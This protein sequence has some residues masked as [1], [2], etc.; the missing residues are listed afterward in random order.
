VS[1]AASGTGATSN[2]KI[3]LSVATSGANATSGQTTFGAIFS[4]TSTGTT[5]VNIALQLA[6]S[7][8]TTNTDL[9]LAGSGV[10]KSTP[11]T[12]LLGNFVNFNAT[13]TT[14]GAARIDAG[15]WKFRSDILVGWVASSTDPSGT[16]DIILRRSAAA[17]LTQ[18]AADVD[19][20]P[21]AQTRSFQ[22]ALAGG[23]SDVAGADTTYIASRGKG[24][25]AAGKFI[26]QLGSPTT[27]G[28]VVHT[29]FSVLTLATVASGA[30]GLTVT[31]NA[32]GGGVSL[33]ST[34]GA[35][36]LTLTSGASA[37]G[38]T[39]EATGGGTNESLILKPKGAGLTKF[40]ASK[41]GIGEV[42][43]FAGIWLDSTAVGAPIASNYAI[44]GDGTGNP[45]FNG[46]TGFQFR[47]ANSQILLGAASS[48]T[49]GNAINL[50]FGTTTGTQ[51]GTAAAQKIGHWGVTPIVQPA[52]ANQAALTDSTTGTAGFTLSD[53]GAVF[54]QATINNNF[55]SLAR[56]VDNMRTALVNGGFMKGAA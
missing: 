10:I 27:S 49:L 40:S 46:P 15:G 21:V 56:L 37:A 19:T 34:G 36:S 30:V 44:L 4:N 51:I 8:G 12:I 26:W 35:V 1:I 23:T 50:I 5:S 45:L 24:A 7:N 38:V 25:G 2:T 52:G 14:T 48:L 55:A 22:N 17:N 28:T 41:I 33:L 53:V 9:Q 31:A 32:A 42:S 43:G 13:T 11:G 16:Q 47:I 29:P 6:A 18:G 39:L 3:G 54:S 20:A